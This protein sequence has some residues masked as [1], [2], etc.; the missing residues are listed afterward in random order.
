MYLVSRKGLNG[1]SKVTRHIHDVLVKIF[2]SQLPLTR[3]TL[4]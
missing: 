4:C 1:F 2:E 3:R